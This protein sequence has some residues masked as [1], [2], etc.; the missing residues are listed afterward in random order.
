MRL[1]R[2]AGGAGAPALVGAMTEQDV[3]WEGSCGESKQCRGAGGSE[4]KVSRAE[5]RTLRVGA[6]CRAVSWG[7]HGGPW[8]PE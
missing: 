3:R 2:R 7:G 8:M 1:M 4:S 6:C 5:G